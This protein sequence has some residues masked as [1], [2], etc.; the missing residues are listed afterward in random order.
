MTFLSNREHSL[1]I[2]RQIIKNKLGIVFNC[3]TRVELL[4]EEIIYYL[5]KV[6]AI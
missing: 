2:L 3:Y 1:E 5:K 6:V 4:D